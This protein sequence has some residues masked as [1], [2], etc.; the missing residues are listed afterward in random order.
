MRCS[1]AAR[2]AASTDSSDRSLGLK[3]FV[4]RLRWMHAQDL[5]RSPRQS[6][7]TPGTPL[8]LLCFWLG[9]ASSAVCTWKC[10]SSSCCLRW[11]AASRARSI[12]WGVSSIAWKRPPWMRLPPVWMVTCQPPRFQ[13]TPLQPIWQLAAAALITPAVIKPLRWAIASCKASASASGWPLPELMYLCTKNLLC[14]TLPPSRHLA[15]QQFLPECQ[16][17][18]LTPLCLG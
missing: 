11:T 6:Q 4:T 7:V 17:M 14:M 10:S 12:S 8:T 13:R 3:H 2:R 16:E 18:P 15:Y 9:C 5:Q 1:T